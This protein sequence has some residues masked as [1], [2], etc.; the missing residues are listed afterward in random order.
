MKYCY[1][2]F[3][4]TSFEEQV[5]Q[6]LKKDLD[7]LLFLPFILKQEQLFIRGGVPRKE[8]VNCFKGYVFLDSEL[9]ADEVYR[10][11][12]DEIQK[13]KEIYKIL[14]YESKEN[15]IL[16]QEERLL[17]TRLFGS[18]FC[19]EV[20]YGYIEQEKLCI[21]KGALMGLEDTVKKIDRHKRMAQI[22][23][24]IMGKERDLSVG[25]DII[26]IK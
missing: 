9:E 25:L 23:I 3:V 24:D 18:N 16:H 4:K 19:L 26:K 12:D 1:V 17:L 22:K 5:V 15:I 2:L 14:V 8:Y 10:I 20:S 21:Y 11:I 13:T 7:P 6:L